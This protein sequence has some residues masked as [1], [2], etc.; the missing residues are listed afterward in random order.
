MAVAKEGWLLKRGPSVESAWLPQ[1]CVLDQNGFTCF[2]DSNKLEATCAI[3]LGPGS[4][5]CRFANIRAPGD[6]PKHRKEKPSGFVLEVNVAAPKQSREIYYFDADPGIVAEWLVAIEGSVKESTWHPGDIVCVREA[7]LSDSEVQVP[8]EPSMYGIVVEVDPEGDTKVDFPRIEGRQWVFEKNQHKIR[9]EK[10]LEPKEVFLE[11]VPQN[12]VIMHW[13]LRIGTSKVSRCYEFEADGVAMS[14]HTSLGKGYDI[15]S[16]RLEGEVLKGH[17]EITSWCRNFA[18]ENRYDA[19]G[20]GLLGGKNCQDFVLELCQFLKIDTEQLPYRQ[21]E[22]VKTVLGAGAL[23]AADAALGTGLL[24]GAVDM[25]TA[26]MSAAAMSAGAA[27]SAPALV[28]A[29]AVVT[30][31][32]GTGE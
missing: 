18:A 3:A 19:M 2:S 24:A 21:A 9:L 14:W 12:D 10:D 15:I 1:W 5:A 11:I 22:K 25:G 4:R 7:F 17:R 23:V 8:L 20:N 27:V 13:A 29:A 16:H 28:A 26:A 30:V 6:S 32:A 31:V